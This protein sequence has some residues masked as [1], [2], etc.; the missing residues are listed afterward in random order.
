MSSQLHGLVA[1]A[2]TPFASDGALN[3]AIVEKQAAHLLA[4]NVTTVFIGGSTGESHSL[5]LDERLALAKRWTEVAR[6]SAL[7]VVVHVG[8]NC[9]NDART[10]AAQAQE[11]GAAAISALS[12]S[13]F[14]PSSVDTLIACCAHVAQAAP[15]TP[16]Y[17]Y[18]I[19][20]LTGV[21]LSMPEFLQKAKDR[22]PTLAGLKFTNVDF[23]S[24][25]QCLSA[26]G[27]RFDIPWGVDE[28]LLSALACGARG[29]VGSTYNFAAPLYHRL[30]AAFSRGDLGTARAEQLRSI[31]LIRTLARR[32]Y[33]ASAKAFMAMQ[34]VEVGPPRLPNVSLSAGQLKELREELQPFQNP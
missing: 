5:S 32:G 3:L 2:H 19:P 20:V 23:M 22:L 15:A 27:G 12:P 13:Y 8:S 1:A 26:E 11:L 7:R 34:G 25:Q 21:S 16:F 6:G 4:N 14:K 31:Q 9:L 28:M 17:Y 18:D 10:L 24:Y 30:I 33:M 29:A